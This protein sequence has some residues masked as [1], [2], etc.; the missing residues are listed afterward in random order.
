[1]TKDTEGLLVECDCD[2]ISGDFASRCE[3]CD[4]VVRP[5]RED[6]RHWHGQHWHSECLLQR[7]LAKLEQAQVEALR[8]AAGEMRCE[9]C[10]QWL[11]WRREGAK[12]PL[13]SILGDCQ[14]PKFMGHITAVPKTFGCRFYLRRSAALRAAGQE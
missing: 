5:Y 11:P 12:T 9:T 2:W 7:T 10:V 14:H 8:E 6:I 13:D 3:G 4:D 1:M